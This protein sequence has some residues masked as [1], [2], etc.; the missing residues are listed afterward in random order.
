MTRAH[1][2][3]RKLFSASSLQRNVPVRWVVATLLLTGGALAVRVT[4]LDDTWLRVFLAGG[5]RIGLLAKERQIRLEAHRAETIPPAV[6]S[7]VPA[8]VDASQQVSE[9]LP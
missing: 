5:D 7:L 9:P 2:M 1:P 8:A 3:P 4:M 6:Q